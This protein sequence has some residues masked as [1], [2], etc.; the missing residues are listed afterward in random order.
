M[1]GL[2]RET[3]SLNHAKWEKLR[4]EQSRSSPDVQSEEAMT[5]QLCM[6]ATVC[7]S[8]SEPSAE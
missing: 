2:Q 4:S 5:R 7:A 8:T 6:L 3:L 1:A